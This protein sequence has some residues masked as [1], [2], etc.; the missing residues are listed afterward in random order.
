MHHELLI[1][2]RLMYG[3]QHGYLI[4]KVANDM[5]GPWSKVSPGTL[6]PLLAK[7]V[8]QGLI[9][10]TGPPPTSRR[11]PRTYTITAAGQARFHDLMVQTPINLSDY[12]QQF[13]LKVPTLGLLSSAE[14]RQVV[15]HYVEY[16]RTMMQHLAKER[17]LLLEYGPGSGA[18]NAPSIAAAVNLMT[19]QEAQWQAEQ[20]W[21]EQLPD[22][23]QAAT[24][25][26]QTTPESSAQ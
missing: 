6:Y 20:H 26:A 19:H 4:A 12:R 22:L 9:I 1:L 13:H 10:E 15:A 14:Q 11:T 3:P 8:Q 16:C 2:A 23:L 18:I 7:L 24:A 5:L 17:R 21:A 25:A